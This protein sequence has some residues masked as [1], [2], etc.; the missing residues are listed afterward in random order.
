ML[1][2]ISP[3]WW[4]HVFQQRHTA[5]LREIPTFK[6]VYNVIYYSYI[7]T[8]VYIICYCKLFRT[9][10][11]GYIWIFK[12]QWR[13]KPIYICVYILRAASL[14]AAS[15]SFRYVCVFAGV[16]K[17]VAHTLNKN[18]KNTGG[19][20]HKMCLKEMRIFECAQSVQT[21]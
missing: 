6:C 18:K 8:Q 1:Y 4:P 17:C 13:L 14:A 20:D 9:F 21:I 5:F 16:I 11:Q 3:C 10:S 2:G 12:F 7:Y 15:Y 19:G